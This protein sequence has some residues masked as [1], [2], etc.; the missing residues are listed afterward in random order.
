M[1]DSAPAIS[2]SDGTLSISGDYP[3][4]P[5]MVQNTQ[6]KPLTV[7]FDVKYILHDT[8]WKLLVIKVNVK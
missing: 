6:S 3:P 2:G 7:H 5:L 4:M 1:F 8:T